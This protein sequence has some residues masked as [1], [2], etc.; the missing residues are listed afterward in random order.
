MKK[1]VSIFLFI[2]IYLPIKM[3]AHPSPNSLILLD[4][5]DNGV[6]V[7]L[8]LPINELELAFGKDI[9]LNTPELINQYKIQLKDYLNQH[10]RPLSIS[11]QKW[12]IDIKNIELQAPKKENLDYAQD[13]IVHLFMQPPPNT[14]TRYFIFD[15]DVILHQVVT[16]NALIKITNDWKSGINPENASELGVINV[17]SKTN[18]IAPFTINQSEGSTWKGFT[19][20]VNLGISHI[21]KGTDHLLFLFTLLLAAPLLINGKKWGNFGG[22]KYSLL[23]L[24]KIITSFTIGH[25]ITLLFGAMNWIN[26]PSQPIEM[27]IAL[28][29]LISAIHAIY[30]V[31][32]QKEAFIAA[33]FGLIH[34]LAFATTLTDLHLIKSQLAL[35]ILGFNVGIE[36][37]QLLI[38]A[39]I[40]PE[41]ILLSKTK[42]YS[43][44]RT[45]GAI[46]AGIAAIAW[47][48][49]RYSGHDNF[50][51]VFIEKLF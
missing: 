26:A 15:Y 40:I 17:D 18:T 19:S 49:Q 20:M 23:R 14:N 45:L 25:S 28:S 31:F 36:L 30:P 2:L 35:S 43:I 4:I 3:S 1:S 37:M 51:T 16:H 11:R 46:L 21:K 22:V 6:A 8:Q 29:I 5:Q 33:G 7:E 27:L 47:M 32:P 38:M 42:Y 13:V 24:I 50:I 12:L 48:I 9:K 44:I 10:I 34:G 41:L 39:L